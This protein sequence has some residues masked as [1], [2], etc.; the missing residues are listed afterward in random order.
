MVNT[1]TR[2]LTF[3]IGSGGE[4]MKNTLLRI[5]VA[6]LLSFVGL[7]QVANAE[8]AKR[9][10]LIVSSTLDRPFEIIKSWTQFTTID[11]EQGI[12]GLSTEAAILDAYNKGMAGME[13]EARKSG[14]DAVINTSFQVLLIPGRGKVGVMFFYGTLVKAKEG[15]K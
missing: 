5:L 6:L 15:P 8:E 2:G 11:T 3:S 14:A 12:M 9:P 13:S 7:V 4:E 1:P 10:I